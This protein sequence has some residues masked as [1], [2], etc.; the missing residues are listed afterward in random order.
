MY[1]RPNSGWEMLFFALFLGACESEQAVEE[2]RAGEIKL[3]SPEPGAFLAEGS[4]AAKGRAAALTGVS[5]NGVEAEV[6]AGSFTTDVNLERGVNVIEALGT[7]GHGDI[8]YARNGVLAGEFEAAEDE[9]ADAIHLR[10]NEGGLRKIG[11]LA[12]EGLQP[13]TLNSVLTAANPVYSDTYAWDTVTIAADVESVSFDAAQFDFTPRDGAL[14]LEVEIPNLYVDIYAY[15]DALG[16]GFDSDVAMWASSAVLRADVYAEAKRGRIAVEIGEVTVELLDFGYDTTLLP[17]SVEDYLLVDTIRAT[18]EEMLVAKIQ[19]MV[20]PLLDETLS[21]LDPSYSTELMGLTVEMAFSFAELEIDDDGIAL[22]MDMEI[23]VPPSGIHSA[24]GYLGAKLGTPDVD[25]H[26]DLGGA[27]SDNLIN[28]MLYEAWQG[29]LLDMTLSTEDGSLSPLMLAPLKVTEGSIS[30]TALLPP[31][32]VERDGQLQAQIGELLVAIDAPG[33][34]LGDHLLVSVNAFAPL[35]VFAADGALTLKLGTPDVVL[36]VR[37][38]SAGGTDEST[39]AL[40]EEVLPLDL[41]FSLIGDFS[42]PLPALYGIEIDEGSASRD[43]S[44]VYTALEVS[45]N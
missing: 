2:L 42:F 41:L 9:V 31:V 15:G 36:M 6:D 37:E 18:L 45:L 19:E 33:N 10:V 16:F 8:H 21:G 22:I 23:N 40:I 43:A 38:S 34:A 12:A 5:V 35:E 24:P 39:T 3:T 26:A 20:P 28:R 11:E 13:A 17:G 30:V 25:T 1:T 29:G 4:T 7:D 14:A 44:G 32:V 27:V